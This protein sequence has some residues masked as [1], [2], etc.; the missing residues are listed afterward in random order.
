LHFKV[1]VAYTDPIPVGTP[2]TPVA[3]CTLALS[4]VITTHVLDLLLQSRVLPFLYLQE[5]LIAV[6]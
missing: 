5:W 2:P 1:I 4:G 6:L 3:C